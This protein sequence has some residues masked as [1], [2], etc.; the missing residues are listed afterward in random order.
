[1][2]NIIAIVLILVVGFGIYYVASGGKKTTDLRS[3]AVPVADS[4]ANKEV[5][6]ASV[7]VDLKDF[8]FNP[9]VQTVKVGTNVTWVNNDSVD[10][11]VTSDS[12]NLLDS[13]ILSPGQSFSFTFSS[14]GSESYHCKIHPMMKGRIVVEN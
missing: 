12:G 11:T 4:V 5:A 8:S 1:M 3:S 10:H 13:T 2:K 9:S 7:T 14:L 6:P